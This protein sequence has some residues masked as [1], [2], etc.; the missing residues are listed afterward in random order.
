MKRITTLLL[1]LLAVIPATAWLTSPRAAAQEGAAPAAGAEGGQDA[2][3]KPPKSR[4]LW[5]IYS[6]GLIGLFI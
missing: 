4:F 1:L 3:P 6:S 5:F 2:A